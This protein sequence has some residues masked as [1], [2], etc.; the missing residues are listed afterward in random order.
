MMD[1]DGRPIPPARMASM[2]DKNGPTSGETKDKDKDKKKGWFGKKNTGVCVRLV[3]R[4][5]VCV[6]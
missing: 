3:R 5:H 6:V 1:E 2:R 4:V